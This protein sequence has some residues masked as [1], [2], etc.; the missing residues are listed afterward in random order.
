MSR[1]YEAFYILRPDLKQAELNAQI[2][3]FQKVVTDGGGTV[4]NVGEWDRRKLSYEIKGHKEGVYVLMNFEADSATQNELGRLM[5]ISD[6][7]IRHTI[8]KNDTPEG[9]EPVSAN[10]PV[11]EEAVPYAAPTP[12]A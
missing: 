7:V 4:A 6:D 1:K 3:R 5:R 10:P 9:T 2:Q 11:I 8:L 12:R